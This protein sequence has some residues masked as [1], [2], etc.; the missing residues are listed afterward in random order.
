M[1]PST[2]CLV[3]VPLALAATS[4]VAQSRLKPGLWEHTIA[5]RSDSGQ[6]EKAMAEARAQ[7]AQQPPERRREIEQ[8][9]AA[10]G[11]SFGDAGTT[12]T[13]LRVCLTAANAERGQVPVQVG[14]CRQNIVSRDGDVSKISFACLSD[15]PS[16]GTGELRVL[17]PTSNIATARV[18]TVVNGKPDRIETTQRGTWIADDCG[19]VA[20]EAD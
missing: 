5:V 18:D 15:P 20:P 11:V 19:S 13:T 17:S 7:I 9:M 8:M 4:A 12:T 6:V 3:A 1:K 16:S 2:F 14:D 10:R